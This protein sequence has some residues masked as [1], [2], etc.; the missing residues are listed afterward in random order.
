MTW[1]QWVESEYNTDGF[2]VVNYT[3]SNAGNWTVMDYTSEWDVISWETIKS[4]GI[5]CTEI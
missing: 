5:Y 2:K 3:V 1:E 4:S